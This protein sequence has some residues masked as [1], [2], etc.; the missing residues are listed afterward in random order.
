MIYLP[1]IPQR[2]IQALLLFHIVNKSEIELLYKIFGNQFS[3]FP[4][5]ILYEVKRLGQSVL[6]YLVGFL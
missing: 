4:G 5:I 6:T 2:L 1:I 3:Y